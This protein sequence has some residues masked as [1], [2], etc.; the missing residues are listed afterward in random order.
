M[1]YFQVWGNERSGN[2]A[3]GVFTKKTYRANYDTHT[4]IEPLSEEPAYLLVCLANGEVLAN[5]PRD[6]EAWGANDGTGY[7][8]TYTLDRLVTGAEAAKLR[9]NL[10]YADLSAQDRF[11]LDTVILSITAKTP[12]QLKPVARL[13]GV[14]ITRMR[15]QDLL[16]VCSRCS[17]TGEHLYNQKD[18]RTCWKCQGR[19]YTMPKDTKKWRALVAAVNWKTLYK[20]DD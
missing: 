6:T 7:H 18:G 10:E 20:E 12:D 15:K 14:A 4:D 11:I 16:D 13:L 8:S 9:F 19:R 5:P 3:I 2:V 17:G 1:R